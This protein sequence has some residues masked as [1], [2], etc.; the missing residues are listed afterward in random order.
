MF[1]KK[2]LRDVIR[3]NAASSAAR[4]GAA[5]RDAV[6]DHRGGADQTDDLTL[7]VVKFT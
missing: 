5:I 4:I 1:G 3:A 2:R 6:D 7:V